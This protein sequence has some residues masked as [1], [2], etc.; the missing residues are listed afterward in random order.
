MK[1]VKTQIIC[2]LGPASS[3]HSVLLKMVRAG[4]DVVRLNFSHGTHES[5][6]KS[7][8]LIR[9]INA[10]Y[11]RRIKILQDLEG[12]RIRIGHLTNWPNQVVPLR[13]HQKVLLSNN[14]KCFKSGV[15]PFDYEGALNVIK[16]G[17]RIYIDDGNIALLVK[18][19]T[20][21]YLQAV[22]E[23]PGVVK[24]HKGINIPDAKLRFSGITDKDRCDLLFGIHHAVDFVAQSFV[25][26]PQ[27][28]LDVKKILL[29]HR[30]DAQ[31][32]AKI[33][34]REAVGNINGI[35]SACDGI[36]IARGDLG[37]CLPI[38]E[39]PF[40]Q[41]ML[42]K[43]SKA[44][45]KFAITATQ[46]LESMTGHIRPTRA[47]VTDVANAVIDGTNYTMLS[48][49]SAAGLYPVEAVKMM[50]TVCQYTEKYLSKKSR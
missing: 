15:I 35:L 11:H 22:V 40:L 46:M 47:E 14:P 8:R 7:I 16:P 18:S 2:T 31:V 19:H 24:E 20:K 49:E 25:R 50:N 26:T 41:K 6:L 17:N 23:V 9:Q 43:K 12:F 1:Q 30:S 36:M 37:V 5:H 44:C 39:I 34:S 42:I 32:I 29:R 38:Y 33:E 21:N 27:D 48:E 10:K 4:M 13:K 3:T 28:V 45:R